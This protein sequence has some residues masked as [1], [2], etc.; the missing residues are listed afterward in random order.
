VVQPFV[1][2]GAPIALRNTLLHTVR[3]HSLLQHSDLPFEFGVFTNTD[4]GI[5]RGVLAFPQE[6]YVKKERKVSVVKAM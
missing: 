3:H 6:L 5:G 4:R 2:F 1:F